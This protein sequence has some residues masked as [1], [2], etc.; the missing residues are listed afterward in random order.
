M[1]VELKTV[2][3][4]MNIVRGRWVSEAPNVLAVREPTGRLRHGVP[5]GDLFVIVEVRGDCDEEDRGKMSRMLAETI[6]DTYYHSSGSV[7]V[8]LRRAMLAANQQLLAEKRARSGNG[9]DPDRG[10]QV[11]ETALLGGVTAAVVRGEDV[12]IATVG[13]AVSYTVT[14]GVVTQFPGISPWLD[15]ANPQATGAPALGRRPGLDVQL[16]HVLVEPGDI[17]VLGDSRFATH[18][19][20]ARVEEA[21]AYQGVEGA[22]TNLGRLT[23]GHD[24]TGL[25]VEIQAK[26]RGPL[27]EPA[28]AAT[29]ERRS[30]GRGPTSDAI[31][32]PEDS[33]PRVTVTRLSRGGK[34]VLAVVRRLAGKIAIGRWLAALVRGLVVLGML[35]WTGLRTIISR[36]LPNQERGGPSR[37]YATS[38]GQAR[39][40]RTS[41]LPPGA[42]RTVALLIPVVIG[43]VVGLTYWQKGLARE[44]EFQTLIEQAQITYQQAVGAEEATARDLLAQTE[45]LLSQAEAIKPGEAVIGELRAS[46]TEHQDKIDRVERLYWVGELRSYDEPGTQPR[47]VVVNGLDVYVLDNGNDQ[48]YHHQLDEAN[49]ALEADEGDP[50]LVRRG[51]QVETAVVGELIDLVWMPAGGNR[52][53]SDLLILESSGLLEFNPSW[54]LVPVAIADKEAWISP[55]AISSYFGNLYILDPQAGQ[56]LRYLP[57]ADDYTVPAESYFPDDVTVD[58]TGAVD[59]AID[60]FI[61]VLYA[62]GTIRKFEGGLPVEFQVSQIDRP[63]NRATAI[64]TAPD[65]VAQYVYVADAGNKRVVQL[66]KDGRFVRQFKPRDE[67]SVDFNTLRSIFV[68]ELS[69]KLYLLNDAGLYVANITP[70]E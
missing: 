14:R 26:A 17:L 27:R 37:R 29:P 38:T 1:S 60:G 69:G 70:L 20:P 44:N 45:S 63:M 5:K 48:V 66:N 22:L 21:V 58:L 13:P 65:D 11:D 6:R 28:P 4:Q 52:Q 50:V 33:R 40:I 62:D 34:G 2:M 68:D 56:I 7:T 12:F 39:P 3:G 15:M 9:D 32:L 64:Y 53:T 54:G 59:L 30:A 57:G 55:V 36:V 19:S 49:D 41:S 24:C 18:T 10:R 61:Y 46:L 51:Q 42:L 43:L 35:I 23:G 47:R 67:E 31:P 16:F 25:V 8:S